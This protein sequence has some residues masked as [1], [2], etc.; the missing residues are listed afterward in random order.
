MGWLKRLWDEMT[1]GPYFNNG[2]GMGPSAPSPAIGSFTDPLV[3]T[4]PGMQVPIAPLF[5]DEDSPYDKI[6]CMDA[7]LPQQYITRPVPPDDIIDHLLHPDIPV[8]YFHTV[9]GQ[10]VALQQLR[11][12][13]RRAIQREDH[14]CDQNILFVGPSS[15]GKTYIARR[16]AN[17]ALVLPLLEFNAAWLASRKFPKAEILFGIANILLDWD[18]EWRARGGGED[19]PIGLTLVEVKAG[20]YHPPPM[21]IFIDNSDKLPRHLQDAVLQAAVGP[22][23]LLIT[24]NDNTA[25]CD[26]I[27]WILVATR[28]DTLRKELAARFETITLPLYTEEE[29]AQIIQ[30]NY[31]QWDMN[32]CTV[33]AHYAPRVPREAIDLAESVARKREQKPNLSF[34]EA[35]AAVA[36]N[37]GHDERGVA[38]C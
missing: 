8:S 6:T 7:A 4:P 14:L 20:F 5:E 28:P 34:E 33:I 22:D 29:I 26:R 2:N 35:A 19:D 3:P 31:P 24:E 9:I 32:A 37:I 23:F 27:C 36:R 13:A 38:S 25:R 11:G 21:V 12:I 16:F 10:R 17:N 15:A 30:L 18:K 1:Y